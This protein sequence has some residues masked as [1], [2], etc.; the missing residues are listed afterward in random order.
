[1]SAPQSF[2]Q[3]STE[4]HNPPGGSERSAACLAEPG[5][6]TSGT[7][8]GTRFYT[9][10]VLLYTAEDALSSCDLVA[11]ETGCFTQPNTPSQWYRQVLH[12]FLEYIRP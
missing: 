11:A 9:G 8:S 10:C 2:G 12:G 7:P 5:R 6:D 1:V 4:I 3:W